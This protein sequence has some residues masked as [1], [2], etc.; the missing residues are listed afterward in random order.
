MTKPKLF[1]PINQTPSSTVRKFGGSPVGRS[2]RPLIERPSL[3]EKFELL[4]DRRLCFVV[5]PAGYGKTTSVELFANQYPTADFVWHIVQ[6]RDTSLAVFL[7]RL[8]VS[9]ETIYPQVALLIATMT[10]NAKSLRTAEGISHCVID[11]CDK[12]LKEA[13]TELVLIIDDYHVVANAADVNLFLSQLAR[14]MP[15]GVY[16][17]FTSREDVRFEKSIFEVRQ[18][19]VQITQ[20]DLAFSEKELRA[21]A[22]AQGETDLTDDMVRELHQR[23]GGWAASLVFAFASF[24]NKSAAERSNLL[25]SLVPSEKSLT[26]YFAEE[27]FGTQSEA[28]QHFMLATSIAT[29][30]DDGLACN[31]YAAIAGKKATQ[32]F[33]KSLREEVIHK[34]LALPDTLGATGQDGKERYKYHQLLRDF[35]AS[36]LSQKKR[37]KLYL[38]CS[39]Y[40]AAHYDLESAIDYLLL[41]DESEKAITS[42]LNG[43]EHDLILMTRL[44]PW[45][46]KLQQMRLTMAGERGLAYLAVVVAFNNGNFTEAEKMIAVELRRKSA[47]LKEEF[48]ILELRLLSAQA[49]YAVLAA[50]SNALLKRLGKPKAANLLLA[51]AQTM[52]FFAFA[53]SRTSDDPKRLEDAVAMLHEAKSVCQRFGRRHLVIDVLQSLSFVAQRTSFKTAN[54]AYAERRQLMKSTSSVRSQIQLLNDWAFFLMWA[55]KPDEAKRKAEESLV[56]ANTYRYETVYHN[57]LY[58]IAHSLMTQGYYTEAIEKF[59]IVEY[60]YESRSVFAYSAACYYKT[61]C[62]FFQND[63]IA[64]SQYAEKCTAAIASMDEPS[65]ELRE[66]AIISQFFAKLSYQDF[67]AAQMLFKQLLSLKRLHLEAI[68]TDDTFSLFYAYMQFLK[69]DNNAAFLPAAEGY[70]QSVRS[71]FGEM[72]FETL[73][74]YGAMAEPILSRCLAEPRLRSSHSL[75]RSFLNILEKRREQIGLASSQPLAQK[76]A[77]E[78]LIRIRA[79]GKMLIEIDGRKITDQSWRRAQ[80]R[81][82]FKFLLLNHRRLVSVSELTEQFWPDT[83]FEKASRFLYST[84]SAIRQLLNA[85]T[86]GESKKKFIIKHANAYELNF[87]EPEVDYTFDVELFESH[88]KEASRTQSALHYEEAVKLYKA[89]LLKTDID[90]DWAAF[91]RSSLQS[92]YLEALL[93]LAQHCFRHKAFG[94]SIRFA[95]AAIAEDN[96]CES[97]YE[98]LIRSLLASRET[99]ESRRVLAQCRRTFRKELGTGIPERLS[100][101][102]P[103]S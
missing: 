103:A 63:A 60:Y 49:K 72:Q 65:I 27:V 66:Y 26:T 64:T 14:H 80:H 50:K 29:S 84:I 102:L 94:D 24:K 69:T 73:Y 101:L 87:G 98:F 25:A 6:P 62:F 92:A 85:G 40:H 57:S 59:S 8:A 10:E 11:L 81:W 45:L 47:L 90:Q 83:A 30:F 74:K 42:I 76:P 54:D 52:R 17:V 82:V 93:F 55:G 32:D 38:I 99:V 75:V 46:L 3:M 22:T 7:S 36:K 88:I 9:F 23:T 41:A 35:L 70:V 95:K 2:T 39:A 13:E 86:E 91:R 20:T 97:A 5:A 58:I 89:P 96:I 71:R 43:L 16:L 37:N 15:S 67:E 61:F 4:F 51:Q 77:H 28:V 31:L 12:L 1:P 100:D 79:F 19:T 56:L 44:E 53:V 21:F 18:Q 78:T 34:H 68:H 33:T 48:L